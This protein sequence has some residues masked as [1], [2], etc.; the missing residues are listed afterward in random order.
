MF[1]KKI[2][3]ISYIFP[4]MALAFFAF[5]A[6]AAPTQTII[7][8]DSPSGVNNTTVLV[9]D[10]INWLLGIA[11]AVAILFLVIGGIIYV[12]STGD[13]QRVEQAKKV[14]NYAIIGLI[15]VIISYALVFTLNNIIFG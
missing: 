4:A 6:K 1:I 14:I 11:S 10:V 8:F 3:K 7:N 5:S 2:H 9:S 12:T 15:V 13:D